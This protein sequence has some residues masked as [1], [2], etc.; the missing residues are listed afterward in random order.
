M[1]IISEKDLLAIQEQMK[2]SIGKDGKNYGL[3]A[4]LLVSGDVNSK[5]GHSVSLIRNNGTTEPKTAEVD[6]NEI[7]PDTLPF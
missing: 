3:Q 5:Y 2:E 6:N 4:S 7:D 1:W